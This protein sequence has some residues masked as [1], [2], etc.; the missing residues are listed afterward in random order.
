MKLYWPKSEM[1]HGYLCDTPIHLVYRI[2]GCLPVGVLKEL[3]KELVDQLVILQKMQPPPVDQIEVI[4]AEYLLKYDALLDAQD[5][6]RYV[7]ANLEAIEIV[8]D[9]WK[10]LHKKGDCCIHA[11]CVMGN[12]VHVILSGWPDRPTTQLGPL[13]ARHK[14]FTN[15]VLQKAGFLLSNAV[16]SVWAKGFFD[17]YIRPGT[18]ELVFDYLVNNPVKAGLISDGRHWKGLWIP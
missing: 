5:Q 10:L 3:T 7:L 11:V 2:E 12:H 9:G 15:R 8:L 1:P 18:Y 4:K 14:R 13:I 16:P 6:S 17:R